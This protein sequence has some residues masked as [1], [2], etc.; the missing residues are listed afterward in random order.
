[1]AIAVRV[2]SNYD[3]RMRIRGM[4]RGFHAGH[5]GFWWGFWTKTPCATAVTVLWGAAYGPTTD[6]VGVE[7]RVC[8]W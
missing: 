1:M 7:R 4:K 5:R 6:P 3:L 8:L 2:Q